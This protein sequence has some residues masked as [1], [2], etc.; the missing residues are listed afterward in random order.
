MAFQ[1]I[2]CWRLEVEDEESNHLIARFSTKEAADKCGK[3]MRDQRRSIG[4]GTR[5]CGED[6]IIFDTPEEFDPTLDTKMREAA[7]AKLSN[8][9][10]RTLGLK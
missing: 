7:L 4:Y 9:E 8:D 5:V 1:V 2:N 10:K 6:I 3:T